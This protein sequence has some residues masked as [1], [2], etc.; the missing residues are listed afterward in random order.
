MSYWGYRFEQLATLTEAEAAAHEA[1]RTN[2]QTENGGA[3]GGA[4]SGGYRVPSP[5]DVGSFDHLYPPDELAIL[6]RRYADA[7][8]DA[9]G[10]ATAVA[11]APAGL[12][13]V[14]ANE[15][16]C[17]VVQLSIDKV[18]LL[19]AAEIDCVAH[20][21]PSGAAASAPGAPCAAG[22]VELKT[23]RLPSSERETE[24]F[25]R[26]KLLKF[27][28]QSFLAD[29]PSVI[30]GFRDDAGRVQQLKTYETRTIHRLV[31]KG[32]GGEGY[33]DPTV[34]FNFGK[35]VLDWVL[36]QVQG[37]P[38]GE[39]L[40]MRYTPARSVIEML[41]EGSGGNGGEDGPPSAKRAR[42]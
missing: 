34:C 40:V 26:H 20:E 16:F 36:Q 30:V 3:A 17:S 35:G 42:T 2:G 24:K 27:W 1:G 39:K 28:L 12:G 13:P 37:Y 41:P 7:E 8:G 23:S 11:P 18:K 29:V 10:E 15:E 5:T 33:W 38:V 9:G 25:E 6:R 4:A 19:M 31:R 21:K 14:N 22:Y 32:P